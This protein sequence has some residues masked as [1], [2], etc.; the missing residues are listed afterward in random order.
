MLLVKK[1][2]QIYHPELLL[3][4]SSNSCFG[5]EIKL[6]PLHIEN[7]HMCIGSSIIQ[8]TSS[9]LLSF[10]LVTTKLALIH[11]TSTMIV[12]VR[13]DVIENSAYG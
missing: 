3:A 5:P 6:L 4:R 12:E 13:D 7:G 1:L 11:P 8:R 2:P 10:S 9:L